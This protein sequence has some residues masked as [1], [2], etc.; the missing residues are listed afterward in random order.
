MTIEVTFWGVRGS[1]AAPGEATTRYGGNTPCVAIS[2]GE[3]SLLVLDAGTGIRAF[4][5]WLTTHRPAARQV[6]IL[7]S[8]VHWDHIQGLPFFKPLYDEG[9]R[10]DIRGPAPEG[11]SL[12]DVLR[13]QMDPVVF[14][15]PLELAAA[16]VTVEEIEPGRVTISSLTVETI[17]LQHPG[18]TFGYRIQ[19][20]VDGP[21]LGYVTD[22]ELGSGDQH[23]LGAGWY[24][25]MVRTLQGVDVLVHDAMFTDAMRRE[26]KGW[27]HSTPGEAV[28]LAL[29]CDA[30]RLVLFHYDPAHDDAT[31]DLMVEEARELAATQGSAL[32]VEGA[33]EGQ[34]LSL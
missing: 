30:K 27:G 12:E 1:I 20:G 28:K 31:L 26:R 23:R 8:H 9:Y 11:R 33:R 24:D 21:S 2:S 6:D 32:S 18:V 4:G 14:P 10:I 25:G 22:N 13:Q 19:A 16:E 7:L 29:A 17:R 34:T 5:K 15:V 3:D